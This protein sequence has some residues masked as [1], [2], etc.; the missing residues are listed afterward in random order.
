[1]LVITYHYTHIYTYSVHVCNRI[2]CLGLTCVFG[3]TALYSIYTCTWVRNSDVC[4]STYKCMHVHMQ[5]HTCICTC[6]SMLRR[7]CL[8]LLNYTIKLHS[9]KYFFRKANC[10]LQNHSKHTQAEENFQDLSVLQD[11]DDPVSFLENLKTFWII[12]AEI[13]VQKIHV[14]LPTPNFV[15]V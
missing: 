6:T 3:Y 13:I 2:I 11:N 7:R 10:W 1:M 5:M 12:R 15:T 8:G 9:N 14:H 4:T